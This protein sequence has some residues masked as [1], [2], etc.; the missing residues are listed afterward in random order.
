VDDRPTALGA[1]SDGTAFYAPLGEMLHDGEEHVCCHLCGRWM[2]AVGGTHLRWHGWTIDA[3]RETFQLREHTPTCAPS[4][5]ASLRR[6]AKR[7]V[8]HDGFGTHPPTVRATERRSPRWRSLAQV[9]HDLVTELYPERNGDLDPNQVAAGSHRK[10]WWCC[11]ACGYEWEASVDNRVVR[12]SGCPRC[13]IERRA[14]LRTRVAR[15]RSLAAKQPELVA[16]LHPTRNDGLDPSSLG[17][18]STRKVWWRCALCGHE[19]QATVANR[20]AGTGC[21]ACWQKRRGS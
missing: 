11:P 21:P 17:A 2:K 3:Y 5:S 6:A 9:R 13:A 8:G 18:A 4:L 14:A 10:L 19:W 12:K 20:S 16:E 7:R 1:L 15:K